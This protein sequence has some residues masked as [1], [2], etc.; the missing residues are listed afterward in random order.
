MSRLCEFRLSIV[1]TLV[2]R[3]GYVKDIA[4]IVS[5][6]VPTFAETVLFLFRGTIWPPV[7]CERRL[8][9]EQL[10]AIDKTQWFNEF[11]SIFYR[12]PPPKSGDN[13]SNAST[14]C[15]DR[16][17]RYLAMAHKIASLIHNFPYRID[18]VTPEV[19]LTETRMRIVFDNSLLTVTFGLNMNTNTA[20]TR[21]NRRILVFIS[22]LKT[23]APRDP[24]IAN[25]STLVNAAV[26]VNGIQTQSLYVSV[27]SFLH[28]VKPLIET[29]NSAMFRQLLTDVDAV[30]G[31]PVDKINNHAEAIFKF[32]SPTSRTAI[33]ETFEDLLDLAEEIQGVLHHN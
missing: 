13:W 11:Q 31:I 25:L 3:C 1:D 27:A 5:T 33:W 14:A 24:I 16:E 9:N 28:K 20:F 18:Y 32:L 21:F 10:Y 22:D 29:R 12:A 30:H 26:T 19:T 17:G 7:S 6:F 4:G 15:F 23:L 8:Q 2:T